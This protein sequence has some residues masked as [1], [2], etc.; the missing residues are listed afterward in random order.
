MN[1]VFKLGVGGAKKPSEPAAR[2]AQRSREMQKMP[3]KHSSGM[4]SHSLGNEFGLLDSDSEDPDDRAVLAADLRDTDPANFNVEKE[5]HGV[6]KLHNSPLD[7][8]QEV[9]VDNKDRLL[10]AIHTNVAPVSPELFVDELDTM[11]ELDMTA[12]NHVMRTKAVE[13][14]EIAIVSRL[15][16]VLYFWR[17]KVLGVENC[18]GVNL[19]Y[20]LVGIVQGL[21]MYAVVASIVA[22][23]ERVYWYDYPLLCM[24]WVVHAFLYIFPT[25]AFIIA[26]GM[27]EAKAINFEAGAIP[28]LPA[29]LCMFALMVS[30]T[31]AI[32]IIQIVHMTAGEASS[33]PY[34]Q[35]SIL[36]SVIV[37]YVTLFS[38]MGV[39]FINWIRTKRD[40]E[41]E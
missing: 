27:R 12:V 2:A 18:F 35:W 38:I 28:I 32:V 19:I 40:D 10:R 39:R 26:S 6:M 5:L 22:A 25:D 1:V 9:A 3:V 41:D 21:S 20:Q 37:S 31:V 15:W 14:V 36:F 11:R 8:A 34:G 7:L 23:P 29:I 17:R 16:R 24:L 4:P 13:L 33:Y 30:L